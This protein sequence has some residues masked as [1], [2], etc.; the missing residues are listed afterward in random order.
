MLA[1][2]LVLTAVAASAAA[3]AA[4]SEP[5]DPAPAQQLRGEIDDMIASGVPE[6]DP[7]VKMLEDAVEELTEADPTPPRDPGAA[8]IADR[9]AAAE[10]A[11]EG[12][13]SAS[14]A[15]ADGARPS[16]PAAPAWQSGPVL[17]EVVPGQ[18]GPDEIAG[19]VCASVP[20]PDGTA[21]YVAVTPDGT[22]RSVLFAADGR[23]QRLD[24]V[25][26]AAAVPPRSAV[27][28]SPDGRL[29]ITPPGR[30][31]MTVDLP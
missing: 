21:R 22:V 30:P 26:A 6:D 16:A 19:A 23:V 28:A 24:D 1:A 2:A 10:A 13:G 4:L 14:R 12:S 8:G 18:L 5:P 27:A 3:S 17:C 20:Q 31:A 25:R 15:P 7:K 9:I 11:A 29:T